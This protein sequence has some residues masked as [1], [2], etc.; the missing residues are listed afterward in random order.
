MQKIHIFTLSILATL[1]LFSCKSKNQ[2]LP[3]KEIKLEKNAIT[4]LVNLTEQVKILE[5]NGNYTVK[6]SDNNKATATIED[7]NKIN[8]T[9]KAEGE[10]TITVTDDRGKTAD[11]Q[12][13]IT[14]LALSTTEAQIKIN[15]SE[16]I[17][18]SSGS[19]N[20]QASSNNTSIATAEIIGNDVKITGVALGS[21]IIT[22]VDQKNNKSA[23]IT[24]EIIRDVTL[25]K[26]QIT[27]KNKDYDFVY[28]KGADN[29]NENYAFEITS[30]PT[31]IVKVQHQWF[32]ATQGHH[33]RVSGIKPGETV[34]TVKDKQTNQTMSF[35]ATVTLNDFSLPTTNIALS[36]GENKNINITGNG[37]YNV[38]SSDT[39]VSTVSVNNDILTIT[40]KNE[41]SC[42]IVVT[43][44]LKKES[45][46]IQV[47]VSGLFTTDN[48]G[49]LI[50]VDPAAIKSNMVL[51]DKV[52]AIKES[53]FSDDKV[54]ETIVL[55]N[56][57]IVESLAFYF[58]RKLNS[59]TFG[60]KI[61]EIQSDA[62]KFCNQLTNVKIGTS[63]PP[64]L[65]SSANTFFKPIAS[66]ATLRV[67][68]GSKSAYEASPWKQFFGKIIEE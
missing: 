25:D 50:K 34:V 13:T 2:Q 23:N 15:T 52:K 44:V 14:D 1:F 62:F 6:V 67:P 9:A 37:E 20:Y 40:A 28:I 30:N 61:K 38:T 18:I 4:I 19:G 8:I 22:V 68:V 60:S 32:D 33:L 48:D 36:E 12:A 59:V 10:V 58:N 56:V 11:I 63:V 43:D 39:T 51:P 53:L 41:G 66:R 21:A 3:A 65:G 55:P 45:L 57:E 46:N 26:N 16:F 49:K 24:I 17:S 35:T 42:T 47:T 64:I 29:N 54:I 31:D 5:G 7:Q 27:V